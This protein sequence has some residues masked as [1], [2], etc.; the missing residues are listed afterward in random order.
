MDSLSLGVNRKL[1]PITSD[2]VND[3]PDDSDEDQERREKDQH[4]QGLRDNGPVAMNRCAFSQ[5]GVSSQ[6]GEISVDCGAFA[7][8]EVACR[9]RGVSGDGMTRVNRDGAE[10]HSDIPG[11]LTMDMDGAERAGDVAG[12]F[13]LGNGDIGAKAGAIV[14]AVMPLRVGGCGEKNKESG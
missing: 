10:G 9:D 4:S 1:I 13:S 2:K 11:Y 3:Q 14:V 12:R 7:K 6:N 5:A 8:I